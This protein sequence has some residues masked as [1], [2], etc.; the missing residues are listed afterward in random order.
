[1]WQSKAR[2]VV[3]GAVRRRPNQSGS[4]EQRR[5]ALEAEP[6]LLHSLWRIRSRA[7]FVRRNNRV[8]H[9]AESFP[10]RVAVLLG[11][12]RRRLSKAEGSCL[13]SRSKVSVGLQRERLVHQAQADEIS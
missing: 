12:R 7:E 1:M 10:A 2:Y 13:A 3:T 9:I 8:G 4:D 6:L 5:K 11:H